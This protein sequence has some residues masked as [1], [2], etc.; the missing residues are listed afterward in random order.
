MELTSTDPNPSPRKRGSTHKS[1]FIRHLSSLVPDSVELPGVST[2]K[3]EEI[4][5][6]FASPLKLN[7]SKPTNK[8]RPTG[9]LKAAVKSMALANAFSA[10]V[11]NQVLD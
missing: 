5:A 7:T 4:E 2:N 10:N 1:M 8:M 11:K 3:T 6:A 9:R